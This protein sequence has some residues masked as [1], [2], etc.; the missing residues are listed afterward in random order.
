MNLRPQIISILRQR[1]GLKCWYCGIPIAGRRIHVDHI[2]S[3]YHGGADAVENYALAC[4]RCNYAKGKKSLREF[5]VWIRRIRN[6]PTFPAT[7]AF[8]E[9]YWDGKLSTLKNDA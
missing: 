7:D 1:Y 6:L 2:K 9:E 8:D 4:Q 5:F 3:K